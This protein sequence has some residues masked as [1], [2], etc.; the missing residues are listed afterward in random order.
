M[1]LLIFAIDSGLMNPP[2]IQCKLIISE[3]EIRGWPLTLSGI[4]AVENTLGD[5]FL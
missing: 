2:Q 3:D 4:H 1:G 5:R